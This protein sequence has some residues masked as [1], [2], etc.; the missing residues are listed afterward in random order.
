MN[1]RHA[2]RAL[3]ATA[4]A[5]ISPLD[6]TARALVKLDSQTPDPNIPPK[7]SAQQAMDDEQCKYFG[8]AITVSTNTDR[9]EIGDWDTVAFVSSEH[10]ALEVRGSSAQALIVSAR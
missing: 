1:R 9:I 8:G 3:G 4:I 5:G 6:P 7:D 2:L 10:P